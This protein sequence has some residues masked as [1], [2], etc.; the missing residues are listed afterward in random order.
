MLVQSQLAIVVGVAAARRRGVR[1]AA[2]DVQLGVALGGAARRARAAVLV[3]AA[4]AGASARDVELA[5]AVGAAAQTRTRIASRVRLAES[6]RRARRRQHTWNE[7]IGSLAYGA[8]ALLAE[9]VERI[10]V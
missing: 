4:A 5:V 2:S 3:A 10:D 7:D 8:L 1:T 6:E 9:C